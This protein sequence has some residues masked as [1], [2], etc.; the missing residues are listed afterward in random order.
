MR[1]NTQRNAP[2]ENVVVAMMI[3]SRHCVYSSSSSSS[4]DCLKR[5]IQPVYYEKYNFMSEKY[6]FYFNYFK[7]IILW[8]CQKIMM[9]L[10]LLN[11]MTQKL[12]NPKV[13]FSQKL[14]KYIKECIFL[15][16]LTERSEWVS[17]KRRQK[18]K[19]EILEGWK[20]F[21]RHHFTRL[22]PCFDRPEKN[23]KKNL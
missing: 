7:K 21:H 19:K 6:F 20:R 2:Y 17:E 15:F 14:K 16:S 22:A 13:Y 4:Q 9:T 10:F 18:R 12:S 5:S 23:K 11:I 3:I 1:K 8:Q